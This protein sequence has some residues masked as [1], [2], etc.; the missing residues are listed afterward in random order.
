MIVNHL[1][2]N[3]NVLNVKRKLQNYHLSQMVKDLYS[4]EI[5]IDQEKANFKQYTLKKTVHTR[6]VFL[7]SLFCLINIYSF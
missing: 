4:A 5:A 7:Y 6:A 1:Q 3:G 2:E